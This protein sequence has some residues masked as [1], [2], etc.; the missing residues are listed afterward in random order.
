M[1]NRDRAAIS[2]LVDD[3]SGT[4]AAFPQMNATTESLRSSYR[5]TIQDAA[6]QR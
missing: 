6:E 5:P 2:P 3:T 1:L 4:N